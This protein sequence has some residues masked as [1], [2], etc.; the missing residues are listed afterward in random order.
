MENV[1]VIVIVA[2]KTVKVIKQRIQKIHGQ[3]VT[4]NVILIEN[5]VEVHLTLRSK[6][7]KK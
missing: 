4:G 6:V 5:L 1:Q 2:V 7:I 3:I